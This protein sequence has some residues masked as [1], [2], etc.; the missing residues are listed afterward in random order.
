MKAAYLSK[1]GNFVQWPTG[2][3]AV[4]QK[5]AT[6]CILGTDPFGTALDDAVRGKQISGRSVAVRRIADGGDIAGCQILYTSEAKPERVQSI[7]A[8]VRGRDVLTVSDVRAK[9]NAASIIT[10]VI[11]KNSVRFEID[12]SAAAQNGLVISSQLLALATAVKTA[13]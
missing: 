6:I 13:K 9:D 10:F 4:Q 3:K 12:E 5:D 7:L 11:Q 8:S 1:F 2:G